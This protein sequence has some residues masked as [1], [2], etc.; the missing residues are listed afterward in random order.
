MNSIGR[1]MYILIWTTA[2]NIYIFYFQGYDFLLHN[3]II[4]MCVLFY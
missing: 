3:L 1:E 2:Y 4:Q